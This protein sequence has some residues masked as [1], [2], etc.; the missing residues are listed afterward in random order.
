MSEYEYVAFQAVDGPL[1]D[2]Q[3]EFAQRQSTRATV[4]RWSL[5]VEYHY[6]S[7][8][9]DVNGL[10][11]NGYDVYLHHSNYGSREIRLRLPGGIPVPKSVWKK[12]VIGG[13][14]CWKADDKGGGG[15]LSLCPYYDSGELD[16][17]WETQPSLDAAISLRARL[18]S[19]D[20]R[21]L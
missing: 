7:F 20:L 13:N 15:I 5:S 14:L 16:E 9:G 18:M 1:N 21:A 19:G 10:L 6:S 2:E 17:I 4:S 8:R 3:L 12:Y 11:Q